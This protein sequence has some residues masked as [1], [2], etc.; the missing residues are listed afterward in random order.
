MGQS[1]ISPVKIRMDWRLTEGV[2]C[3]VQG[4]TRN[5]SSHRARM[6]FFNWWHRLNLYMVNA[7]TSTTLHIMAKYCTVSMLSFFISAGNFRAY[8]YQSRLSR[9]CKTD[10]RGRFVA[11]LCMEWELK[12]PSPQRIAPP[13]LVRGWLLPEKIKPKRKHSAS[14][15]HFH[16]PSE[17]TQS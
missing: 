6:G 12:E 11:K 10:L 2:G 4:K 15:W 1:H 7:V 9:H 16:S 17:A 3:H 13:S 5:L 8:L 14:S